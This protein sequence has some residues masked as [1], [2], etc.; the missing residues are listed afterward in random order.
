M[1]LVGRIVD[2]H[3]ELDVRI[4]LL[5]C[6]LT[7]WA[8]LGSTGGQELLDSLLQFLLIPA[9]F[10]GEVLQPGLLSVRLGKDI[11]EVQL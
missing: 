11:F 9:H 4:N 10:R 8:L 1:D 7:T 3:N 5:L 6:V 2:L